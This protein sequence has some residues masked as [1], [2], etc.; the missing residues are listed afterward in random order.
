VFWLVVLVLINASP[1]WRDREARL[2]LER[3]SLFRIAS[4]S[5][6]ITSLAAMRLFE[7]GRFALDEP[8]TRWAPEFAHMR[9]LRSPAGALAQTDPAGRLITF[10]DLLT[11]RS[12]FTYGSLQTGPIAQAYDE[13]LGSELDSECSPDEWLARLAALPLIDQPGAAFHYGHS[14]DVLG[15]LLAR[16][17][18]QPL[19]TLLQRQI[20]APLGMTATSFTVAPESRHRRA[21]LY[22]FDAAGQLAPRP[23]GPVTSGHGGRLLAERPAELAYVSGG[24]GLWS[25]VDDYLAIARLFL[26]DGAV[27][28]V[29]LLRP[30]TLALLRTNRLTPSQRA[31]ASLL[32]MRA[33]A[34][35]GFGLG[36]AVV[37]DPA[38]ADL[39][40]C[41][42]GIG[43]VGWPGAYGG[44]WQA[45]PTNDSAM[46]FLAHNLLDLDQLAQGY[47]LGVYSALT[48]FH[49]LATA[50]LA[51]RAGAAGQAGISE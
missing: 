16:M 38:R 34:G 27:D 13:A 50:M 45:D 18:S 23:E 5:K 14:T 49:S 9:V 19:G 8:I 26:G 7:A 31:A 39:L 42:G 40:R 12:G 1:G 28:G 6:P 10:E 30:E 47:G 15:F 20:F 33:F 29:R 24:Q 21:T 43:T 3:D 48:E 17:E 22:G 37:L 36:V 41:R 35:H 32:G 11:H 44:W 4:M 2:P 51:E 25:T 46:I